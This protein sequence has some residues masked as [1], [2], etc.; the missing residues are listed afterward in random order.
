MCCGLYVPLEGGK[1]YWIYSFLLVSLTTISAPSGFSSCWCVCGR[2]QIRHHLLLFT[3]LR[4]QKFWDIKHKLSGLLLVFMALKQ[5]KCRLPVQ[6]A[7]RRWRTGGP[8]LWDRSPKSIGGNWSTR[9]PEM[10]RPKTTGWQVF[11]NW[12]WVTKPKLHGTLIA[13][14]VVT[15]ISCVKI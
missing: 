8:G 11:D 2:D 12:A 10:I 7:P 9:C 3:F 1:T 14:L 15:A 13:S 6:K 5:C 4:F